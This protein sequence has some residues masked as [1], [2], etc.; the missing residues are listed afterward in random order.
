MSTTTIGIIGAGTIGRAL[1]AHAAKT[2]HHVQ[3]SNSRGP[4]TL[5]D[6]A[7]ALGPTVEA[8]SVAKAVDADL[9]VLA[10]PF[11]AVPQVAT[12]SFE[13]RADV[14][15]VTGSEWVAQRL[16]GAHV[17]KAFNAMAGRYVAAAPGTPKAVR[18]SSTPATTSPSTLT[19]PPSSRPSASPPST[20]TAWPTAAG[21][22]SS[23][24]T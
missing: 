22:C 20:S 5:V 17:I 13:G 10:V 15:Q 21:S 4:Q 9:V 6:A 1:A 23:T 3:I 8:V 18:L 2:G 11:V 16:P 19:S 12:A 7:R 24:D 14:G